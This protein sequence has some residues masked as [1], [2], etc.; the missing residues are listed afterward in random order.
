MPTKIRAQTGNLRHVVELQD[1]DAT[2]RDAFNA[3]TK[4]WSTLATLRASIEP[5]S[6]GEPWQGLA[7]RPDTTHLVTLRY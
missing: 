6:G 1:R 5:V 2:A 4:A 7:I 3:P